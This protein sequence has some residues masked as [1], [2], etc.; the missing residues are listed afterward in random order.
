MRPLDAQPRRARSA[1][2][3]APVRQEPAARA[4]VVR[5]VDES[6]PL[7]RRAA[8]GCVVG[9]RPGEERASDRGTLRGAVCGPTAGY[10]SDGGGAGWADE[11]GSGVR[12][13]RWAPP[14][15]RPPFHVKHE[16]CHLRAGPSS[17]SLIPREGSPALRASI[18]RTNRAGATGWA[19]MPFAAARRRTRSERLRRGGGSPAQSRR[20]PPLGTDHLRCE[21]RGAPGQRIVLVRPVPSDSHP[22]RATPPGAM[23]NQGHAASTGT[24]CRGRVGSVEAPVADPWLPASEPPAFHPRAWR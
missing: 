6:E 4:P 14:T 17:R 3:G 19:C 16:K 24:A 7:E 23:G 2:G 10:R 22:E 1:R 5:R 20:P 8:T 13:R 9:V 15:C 12:G 11:A 21:S 18:G